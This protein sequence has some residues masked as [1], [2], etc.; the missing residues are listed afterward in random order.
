MTVVIQISLDR[1]NRIPFHL[2]RWNGPIIIVVFM[3]MKEIDTAWTLLSQYENPNLEF[4]LYVVD[5]TEVT[6]Y[7]IESS[8]PFEV[9]YTNETFYPLN[10]LR[11]IGIESITT[12]HFM[13]VDG[14]LFL[15]SIILIHLLE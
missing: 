3:S 14:D 4:I 10:L 11:D 15:S 9:Q 1:V 8:D 13:V 2:Q 12:T 6:P 7:F 5:T